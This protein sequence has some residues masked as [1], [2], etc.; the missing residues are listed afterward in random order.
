MNWIFPLAGKGSR[1]NKLGKF[2]PFIKI[3]NYTLIDL[4]FFSL[5]GKLNPQDHLYFIT[6][7]EF[8]NKFHFTKKIIQILKLHKVKS[9]AFFKLIDV[10]PNGPAYTIS[11]II[12]D[13]KNNFPCI[14]INGDQ[15]IDFQ[16][17]DFIKKSRIY[18]PIHF[19]NH[20]KSSY[21][22]IN[23]KSEVTSITEKKLI[24]FYASSGV[25]IF[26]SSNLFKTIISL[27]TSIKTNKEINMSDLINL[28]IKKYKKKVY[29][30]HTFAKYDLG[31]LESIKAFSNKKFIV[32]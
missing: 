23:K 30:V 14:V 8:E 6:T 28:Y 3:N 7:K 11:N 27:I 20:G 31:N 13:I 1:T 17:P 24:S 18:L 2:K 25:Y 22:K 10:T 29:P 15:F 26:G 21:V 9:K 4:F 12:N 5:S 19:N 32:F 16:I